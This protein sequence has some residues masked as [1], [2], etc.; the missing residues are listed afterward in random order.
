MAR[1]CENTNKGT[2]HSGKV[3]L[4]GCLM[5]EPEEEEEVGVFQAAITICAVTMR[6]GVWH[7][8]GT[9]RQCGENSADLHNLT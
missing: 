4:I 9:K 8:L 1:S 6:L 5:L 7:I 3:F 2:E